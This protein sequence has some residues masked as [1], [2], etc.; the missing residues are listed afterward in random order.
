MLVPK[1]VIWWDCA[2]RTQCW[3]QL[4]KVDLSKFEEC[5]TRGVG[6]TDID[7]MV[8][9]RDFDSLLIIEQKAKVVENAAQ[10]ELLRSFSTRERC[11][12]IQYIGLV[13][14]HGATVRSLQYIINGKISKPVLCGFS[15]LLSVFSH[16]WQT[17]QLV[18]PS[19]NVH[20]D[21][22]KAYDSPQGD[23]LK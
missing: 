3:V 11:D 18:M 14:Q 7:G 9:N 21:W 19:N 17:G 1:H 23:M 22:L 16:W 2:E 20:Y 13:N 5:F 10:Q 6:F 4:A 15:G 8:H 12:A